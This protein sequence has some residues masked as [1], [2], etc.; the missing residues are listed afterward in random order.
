MLNRSRLNSGHWIILAGIF[1]TMTVTAGAALSI[2]RAYQSA[3]V[4]AQSSLERTALVLSEQAARAF[5]SIE[6]AQQGVFEHLGTE[7]LRSSTQLSAAASTKS[8]HETLQEFANTLPHV[9]ALTIVDMQGNV[10]NSSRRWPV[11]NMNISD[12]DYFK[13]LQS[14]SSL[15]TVVS[16]PLINRG[17]GKQTVI[18]ARKL[19]D[20]NGSFIGVIAGSIDLEYFVSIYRSVVPDQDGAIGLYRNDAT[21]LTRYPT[22]EGAVGKLPATPTNLASELLSRGQRGTVRQISLIDGIER[23]IAVNP[24]TNYPVAVSVSASVAS[25]LSNWRQEAVF[26]ALAALMTNC[27]VGVASLLG[28][29]HIRASAKRAE[30]ESYLARHDALTKLPNRMLFN[31]ELERA[32]RDLRRFNRPFALLMLDLDQFKDVNDTLGHPAGDDLIRSV[33]EGLR[34]CA[35][36]TDLIAR[37]GGDE[38]AI[39]QRSIQRSDDAASLARCVVNAVSRPH[40][41]RGDRVVVGVSAGI[42]LAPYD[43]ADRSQLLSAADLALY[44]A[45]SA[46]KGT[47]R[48][49]RSAMSVERLARRALEHDLRQALSNGEIELAYQ[50]ILDLRSNQ[51]TSVEALLRWRHSRRG[52]VAPDGFIRVAEETGLIGPIGDWV[53]QEACQQAATWPHSINVAVNLSPV[54]FKIRDV[55]TSIAE[56]LKGAALSPE[57]LEVEITES[58]L[59]EDSAASSVLHQI[60]KYGVC[61]ALDDFGTGYASMSY[62]RNFPFR[63]IK[64]DRSFV[65]EL[66]KSHDS[67]AIVYATLDL[68]KR[69]GMMTT[70]EGVE[71]EEQLKTLRN[72]GC[73][74]VQGYLIARP[75]GA[76]D[77]AAFLSRKNA[78]VA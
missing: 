56:A 64:I 28:F 48:F 42:A 6:F 70:A 35:C 73:T 26:I 33:A 7:E 25:I 47:F 77:I 51:I 45:K 17:D 5:E 53:L 10:L 9:A 21:L 4:Q 66:S 20:R 69:L 50:P 43:A 41:I 32:I 72:A 58:A 71:T 2:S 65:Q 44:D 16:E 14:D 76:Q 49:Y 34:A 37:I 59:F 15:K 1:A 75:M 52:L 18:F 24:L 39:I 74:R 3:L 27:A 8:V 46:G 38:F 30:T 78:S 55:M 54:Q 13:A 11:G 62:L 61:I 19:L 68:A 23:I 12:R 60:A 36:E 63:Q 29:R 40:D 67:T 22:M 57:R 31:E